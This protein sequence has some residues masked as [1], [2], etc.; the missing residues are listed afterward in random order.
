MIL[1]CLG[2]KFKARLKREHNLIDLTPLVDVIFLLLI[3]FLVTS[4]ILPLKSLKIEN[5]QLSDNTEPILAQV[6]VIMDANQVIYV[7]SKK[8]IHDFQSLKEALTTEINNVQ[9]QGNLNPTI[10]L[11]IDRRVPYDLFL[12][13][14][15]TAL[16]L[17]LPIRLS[18]QSAES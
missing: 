17:K 6:L 9:S 12:K 3:F 7:G 4:N 1:W 2:M 15:S 11:S 16:E 14:F 5:P 18:Y 10:V 8:A 13:M